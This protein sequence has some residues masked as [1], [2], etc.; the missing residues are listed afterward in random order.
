MRGNGKVVI[1]LFTYFVLIMR[2]IISSSSKDALFLL[3]IRQ[4]FGPL[5]YFSIILFSQQVPF[6]KCFMS[7]FVKHILRHLSGGILV[8][9][10]GL[11]FNSTV[12]LVLQ[13]I[14]ENVHS[15]LREKSN[16]RLQRLQR[17]Y[18]LYMCN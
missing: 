8:G 2:R 14:D 15:Q 18:D 6:S 17:G 7:R 16:D 9:K 3:L 13:R 12:N 1:S 11:L 4:V 10:R 5:V